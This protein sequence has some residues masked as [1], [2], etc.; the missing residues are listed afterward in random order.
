MLWPV[1]EQAG[2]WNA[3]LAFEQ[4]HPDQIPPLREAVDAACLAQG[5]DPAT[6]ALARTVTIQAALRGRTVSIQTPDEEPLLGTPDE[7]AEALRAFANAGI[8]EVQIWLARTPPA[9]IEAFASVLE[10]LDRA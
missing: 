8:D 6:L 3:G 10:R 5:R 2:H 4:S 7:I 1:A 9:E